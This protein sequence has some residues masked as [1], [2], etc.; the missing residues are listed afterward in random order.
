LSYSVELWFAVQ[1]HFNLS[2]DR[3]RLPDP[4]I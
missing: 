1:W 2:G 4:Q 3:V